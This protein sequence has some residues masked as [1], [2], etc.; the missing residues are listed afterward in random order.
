MDERGCFL[1]LVGTSVLYRG[2]V[3]AFGVRRGVDERGW[4]KVSGWDGAPHSEKLREND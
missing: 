3:H 4:G 2:T 1:S